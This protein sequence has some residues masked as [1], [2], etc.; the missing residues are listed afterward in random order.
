MRAIITACVLA[1]QLGAAFTLGAESYRP[2]RAL[3]G[4]KLRPPS[5]LVT[6]ETR[7]QDLARAGIQD[8][9]LETLYH[10]VTT[11]SAG[12]FQARFGI[13]YLDSAFTIAAKYNIRL[14]AWVQAGYWQFGTTGAYNFTEHPEWRA[15]SIATGLPG[16]DGTAGQVFV[17]LC[18]PGP[19][20]KLAAYAVELAGGYPGL[21]GILIDYARFPLD[22]NTSDVYPAPWTYD[23]WTRAAF[24][25]AGFG[26][27]VLT[28]ARSSGPNSSQWSQFL[29]WRRDGITQAVAGMSAAV[30]AANPGVTV[31]G[32]VPPSSPSSS[33]QL[34]KCQNWPAWASSGIIDVVS[35]MCY[36]SSVSGIISELDTTAALSAGRAILPALALTGTVSHPPITDQ[37][38]AIN[39]RGYQHFVFFTADVLA[40]AAKQTECRTWL[41]SNARRQRGDL[42]DD[43]LVD[44][45]D[46]NAFRAVYQ[47]TPIA[48]T[49][50]N[51]R[52]NFNA[53]GLID[54]SD[55]QAF[56]SEFAAFRFGTGEVD[57]FDLTALSRCLGATGPA[58]SLGLAVQHLYD[59]NGDNAV[60]RVDLAIAQSL[61]PLGPCPAD[62]NNDSAVDDADFILFAGAYNILDCAAVA[63]P[64]G[65][66]ADLNQDI[67]VDDTDFVRFAAAYDQL[68]CP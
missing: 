54:E 26:D 64:P 22:D 44:A 41:A 29:A 4:A 45:R 32:D 37:L 21:W 52:M 40:D 23:P 35:P 67:F 30:H 66:R 50:A 33:A 63:M 53:D 3:R 16:G 7:M 11:G 59:L 46:W 51:A 24:Q 6:F 12:V 61:V 27:P 13:D 10:G 20:A 38:N 17:N 57:S 55:W 62:F 42:N 58:A 60:T 36:S 25:A 2:D 19:Q 47:G 39:T 31:Y 28:A 1:G 14:H 68:E 56:R 9:F 18:H 48:V 34:A 49:A 65:C 43:L 5:S 15:T 8:L